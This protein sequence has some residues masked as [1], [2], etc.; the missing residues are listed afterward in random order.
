MPPAVQPR[1]VEALLLEAV[2]AACRVAPPRNVAEWAEAERIVA[3]ESGSP[4]PGKWRTDRVPYLREIMEVMTLS[5]PARRVTFLKSAQIGGSECALNMIGQVMA[6]TPA[7][8]LVMLPSIDMMRGYNRLK[9]DP[10]ITASPALSARVEE[11][12]ARSGEESTATFKRFPGGYLQLLTA[13]SSANLQMRS[14][15]VLVCEE[16]SDYPLDA[17][18]RGDPVK[19]LEA[20]AII[21]AGREKI[22]KV[23]TPAEEGSCRVTAAYEQSSQ[24]QFFVPCPHC[25]HRQTLEW[26]NLR[27]PKGQPQRAL[28][29]CSECG[30]GI[31]P[32]ARPAMLAAGEWVHAKPELITEHA[33]YQ[34]NALYSPTLSWG[35]LAAEF[36]EVKD[37]PEGLKTFTQQKLGRAWRIA[38]EA[39]EWQRLYDR[40]ETWTPGALPA[41]C[42]K[43]TAGVDVQRSPGRVE[44]FVWGWGRNRQSW[45]VDHVV[46]IGS[47]FAWRTWEQ[48]AAVL[49]TIY[50]HASG[51]ALPISLSAVDSGDGT[52]TAEVYAF[53]RKMGQRKVIAVKGRDN[54]PQ[55]IVPGGKV[56][57]KRS[58]KRL[59]HLKPWNVGS[60]Y[61]KGEF[62][63]QLRLEKPTS[64]SGAAY[65]P[66]YVFLPEHLA[67]EEI[68][69]QL[70][71]EEIRRHKVR[72]GV[73]RQEWVKTRERNEALDG[74]VY[75]RAAAAL[76]GIDRW[77]E[78]EWERAARELKQYQA[79]R[80]ALQPALD[81]EEQADDLA[82]PDALPE[83]EAPA[84]TEPMMK[85]PP[86]AKPGRSRFWKQSRAGFA[87]RF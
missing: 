5:H 84:E 12:T 73:F 28:Y 50:P 35:D 85:M 71:S 1:D 43:L 8:V 27:W 47:P 56:D 38:G 29:H 45:L 36:E 14:A 4:W 75:A 42:L 53:V 74:R 3:A 44:V 82:V 13:N 18:G 11:V 61:L 6:E 22:L 30:T 79:S 51:G 16:V 15:R 39:P 26:E 49:E 81:I 25:D 20:R 70:V 34:I 63:G 17:D 86:P 83:D 23:S 87:A 24:G 59:G 66:G 41:G 65:P 40:R 60:S 52:T 9:L 77:Q 69:R 68:C 78:A 80:R 58:G 2:A 46:V 67:G 76:L 19:Q 31:E 32:S 48:V 54:L 7:P 62:Y 57:V 10:M 37:D 72:T 55:A 33:G 21:Y 64:E